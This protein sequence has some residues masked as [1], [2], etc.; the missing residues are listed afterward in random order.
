MLIDELELVDFG[1]APP[2]SAV[3]DLI[4]I[5]ARRAAS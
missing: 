1:Y 2:F 4:H 3:W 5:A